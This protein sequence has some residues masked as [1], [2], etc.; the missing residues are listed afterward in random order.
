MGRRAAIVE[1][2]SRSNPL[3]GRPLGD[4]GRDDNFKCLD[5]EV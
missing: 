2:D 5:C 3:G 1:A 4:G